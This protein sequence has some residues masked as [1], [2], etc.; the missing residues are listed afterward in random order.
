VCYAT[1]IVPL[2]GSAASEQALPT[3]R[4]LA[5]ALRARIELVYVIEEFGF[6]EGLPGL[7]IP[8]QFAAERYLETVAHDL[9]GEHVTT[10]VLRGHAA[11]ALLELTQQATDTLIVMATH[12][13]GGIGRLVFGSVTDKVARGANVPVVTVRVTATESPARPPIAALRAIVVA[14]D[15][16]ELAEAALPLADALGREPGVTLQLVRVVEPFWR[17]AYMS[18]APE[19]VYLGEAQVADIEDRSESEARAYLDRLAS[20]LR[21][22]GLKVVWETRVGRPAEELARSAETTDASLIVMASHGRG[23][24]SRWALGSVAN[25]LMQRGVAPVMVVPSA[26]I[27]VGVEAEVEAQTAP[28]PN[29]S[30]AIDIAGVA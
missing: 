20:R 26:T 6:L 4:A 24:L 3:A 12:G 29:R 11:S 30:A 2:D 21:A 19:A 1:I 28:R 9:P 17:S 16:S 18:I 27:R 14:L 8:D 22:S 23:G 13:R 5:G 25:E 10:R 15:G 7:L